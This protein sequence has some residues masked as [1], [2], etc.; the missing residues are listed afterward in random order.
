[1]EILLPRLASAFP[2]IGERPATEKD[3]FAFCEDRGIAVITTSGIER[4]VYVRRQG[5]DFIFLNSRLRGWELLHVFAHE[6][7]HFI[8]HVPMRTRNVE[9]HFDETLSR[10]KHREAEMAA[11]LLLVPANT[12]EQ[13]LIDGEFYGSESLAGLISLRLDLVAKGL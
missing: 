5:K 11:A 7:A 9:L 4:G 1:M 13:L 10:R 2:F 3:L 12:I 8:L 6:I